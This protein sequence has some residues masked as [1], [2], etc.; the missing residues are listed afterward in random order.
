MPHQ[1]ALL[2]QDWPGPN[3]HTRTIPQDF[4]L[5]GDD[6]ASDSN[7]LGLIAIH[8]ACYGAGTPLWDEFSKQA[9]KTREPIA[10]YPFIAGLPRQLG[11]PQGGALAVI[12]HIE[13]AWGFSFAWPGAR[14]KSKSHL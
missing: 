11:H 7:L 8:F 6:I 14:A 9:F 13:R 5:A 1:G 12:G 2:C 4:Y 3:K 10:P